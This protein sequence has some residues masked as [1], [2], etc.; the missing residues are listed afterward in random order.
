[1]NKK[2]KAARKESFREMDLPQKADYIL[3]YYK[4][5]IIA[6]ILAVI[7][8]FSFV[9][10]QLTKKRPCCTQGLLTFLSEK[11]SGRL[12]T[13]SISAKQASIRKRMRSSAMKPCIC[14]MTPIL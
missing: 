6:V 12:S 3:T 11:I 4:I 14:R 1:M 13:G 2:E 8:L 10:R 7:A 5:P 9:H